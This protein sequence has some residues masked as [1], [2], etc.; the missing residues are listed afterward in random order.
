MEKEI[1]A[2]TVAALVFSM[3]CSPGQRTKED[4]GALGEQ[5]GA[6]GADTQTIRT[7]QAAANEVVR[8]AGDCPAV[9]QAM[10]AAEQA[11]DAAS[12]KIQTTAGQ[13]SLDTMRKQIRTVAEACVGVQ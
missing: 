6:I 3:A 7:A 12:G 8:N 4:P 1:S 10:P 13:Q 5:A 11:I 2:L 9:N